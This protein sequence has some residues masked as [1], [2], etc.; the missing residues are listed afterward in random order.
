MG[1]TKGCRDPSR[2]CLWTQAC[3]QEGEAS[4]QQ[5]WCEDG[6]R[7]GRKTHPKGRENCS[8]DLGPKTKV[9]VILSTAPRCHLV[10]QHIPAASA[11]GPDARCP[12]KH[13][14]EFEG[15][16]SPTSLGICQQLS[17][18]QPPTPPQDPKHSDTGV[19]ALSAQGTL[20]FY[21]V[22]R[23]TADTGGC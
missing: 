23:E 16:F 4:H 10:P 13:K 17:Q 18:Q 22:G 6:R 21:R 20:H 1:G 11:L 9:E 12:H 19:A 3:L 2:V 5:L 7:I 15:R 8:P 14:Q